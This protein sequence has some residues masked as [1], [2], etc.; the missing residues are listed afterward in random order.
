VF[1]ETVELETIGRRVL[2][3]TRDDKQSASEGRLQH[4]RRVRTKW[5]II[6]VCEI[7]NGMG[8]IAL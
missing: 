8:M 5:G 3:I 6:E 2:R 1:S 7:M 4:P